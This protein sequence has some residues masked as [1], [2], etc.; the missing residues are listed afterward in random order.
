MAIALRGTPTSTVNGSTDSTVI[1]VPTGVV[2][3]DLLIMAATTQANNGGTP[4]TVAPPTGWTK[5][6]QIASNSASFSNYSLA[7]FRRIAASEP[8]SY[9]VTDGSPT[10][11]RLDV[12]MIAYSGADGTTPIVLGPVS[13]VGNSD[14]GTTNL[15]SADPGTT[16]RDNC[17]HAIWWVDTGAMGGAPSGYTR[18]ISLGGPVKAADHKAISPAG[19]TGAQTVTNTGG[20]AWACYALVISPPYLV[21]TAADSMSTS[22]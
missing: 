21:R 16:P 20:G 1:N 9:T 11:H 18:D 10:I 8:A 2:D 15:V 3:G 4:P 13:A 14:S 7:L 17:W 12:T 5:F 19:A 22:I 6:G